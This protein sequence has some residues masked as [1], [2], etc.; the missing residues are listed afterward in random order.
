[1][2]N[3]AP[4]TLPESTALAVKAWHESR[5]A[6]K[7][8]PADSPLPD[9]ITKAVAT[10]IAWLTN[11]G[12]GLDAEAAFNALAKRNAELR[13]DPAAISDSLAMQAQLL[14]RVWLRYVARAE[15][16]TNAERRHTLMKVAFTAQ[17]QLV[18]TLGAIYQMNHAPRQ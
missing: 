1:M 18:T 6:A 9:D 14:E 3:S 2:N 13:D 4:P 8:A 7:K 17:R 16:E 12:D 10:A 15:A 11:G 5:L